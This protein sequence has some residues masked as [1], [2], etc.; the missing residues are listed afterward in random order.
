[1][2]ELL[3]GRASVCA[4]LSETREATVRVT[5]SEA[6]AEGG[7]FESFVVPDVGM[8]WDMIAEEEATG[9]I[10]FPLPDPDPTSAVIAGS[11]VSPFRAAS[12][13]IATSPAPAGPGLP[14]KAFLLGRTGDFRSVLSGEVGGDGAWDLFRGIEDSGESIAAGL[15]TRGSVGGSMAGGQNGCVYVWRVKVR[16]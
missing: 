6:A 3:S 16:C 7:P 13:S 5:E 15:A 14:G 10:V 4:A 2:L 12:S 8:M 9:T 11:E 1:M